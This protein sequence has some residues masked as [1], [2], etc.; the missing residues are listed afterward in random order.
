M[1]GWNTRLEVTEDGK[2]LA[3]RTINTGTFS[4]EEI[5]ARTLTNT[6]IC[7]NVDRGD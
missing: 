4:Y 3:S 1:P 6:S 2:V 5:A 7:L